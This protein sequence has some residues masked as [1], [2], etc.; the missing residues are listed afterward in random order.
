MRECEYC[1]KTFEPYS[2]RNRFC[3]DECCYAWHGEHRNKLHTFVCQYCG[4]TYSTAY[5]NRNQYCSRECA[6]A[7]KHEIKEQHARDK[8]AGI[9]SVCEIHLCQCKE[10]GRPFYARRK[11]KTLCSRECALARGRRAFAVYA[12]KNANKQ[13]VCCI[14][15]EAFEAPYGDKRRVTCSNECSQEQAR[16]QGAKASAMRR[17]RKYGN[18]KV[19]SI[20]PR[21]VFE[22]DHWVCGIC[23]GKV[24]GKLKAP[25]PY[26]A[27]LDHIVAL[28]AGGTHTWDNVQCAHLICNMRK[29]D[30]GMNALDRQ[31]FFRKIA[32]ASDSQ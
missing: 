15:G 18:G 19:E 22:R 4:K 2:K 21:A 25:D 32:T 1:G 13:Y 27:S 8:A 30:R 16:R 24:D 3:S 5:E 23:G 20:A 11:G 29:H 14:C 6:F 31:S 17:A 7:H 10:C 26:S 28:A 12:S 9:G